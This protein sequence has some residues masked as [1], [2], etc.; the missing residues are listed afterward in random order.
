[1]YMYCMWLVSI[2]QCTSLI[3]IRSHVGLIFSSEVGSVWLDH[4]MIQILL[5]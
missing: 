5:L 4:V 2:Y 3:A 1:M